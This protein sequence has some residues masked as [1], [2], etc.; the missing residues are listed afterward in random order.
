MKKKWK[1]Q[2]YIALNIFINNIHSLINSFI[3]QIP[4]KF[5][6]CVGFGLIKYK[7]SPSTYGLIVL[8]SKKIDK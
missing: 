5:L 7:H 1:N 2:D 3:Q 6:P 4:I 8:W